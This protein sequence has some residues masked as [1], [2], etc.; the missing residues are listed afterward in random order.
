[1][2]G[3]KDKKTKRQND[4]ITKRQKYEETKIQKKDKKT[5]DT[6]QKENLILRRQGSFALLRCFLNAHNFGTRSPT[7]VRRISK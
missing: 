5:K 7:K 3:Q 6:V 4:K 1:M 2:S